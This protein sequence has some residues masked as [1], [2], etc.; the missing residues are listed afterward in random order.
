MPFIVKKPTAKEQTA[1]KQSVAALRQATN[2]ATKNNDVV[3]EVGGKI[4]PVPRKAVMLFEKVLDEMADGRSIQIMAV[5]DELSTQEAAD[6]LKVSRPHLVKLL[7][8]GKIPYKKV[9]VHRRVL[10]ED[11]K[12]Y[13]A[14]LQKTRKESLDFLVK[15]AQELGLGYD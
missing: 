15:Q 7:E 13:N 14:A 8:T 3:F 12:N 4:I 2:S 11:V 1:A 9:G 6:F 5:N 10:V